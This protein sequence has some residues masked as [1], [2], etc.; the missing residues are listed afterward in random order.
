[1]IRLQRWYDAN[2]AANADIESPSVSKRTPKGEKTW[3]TVVDRDFCDLT[4]EVW[5][6]VL[7]QELSTNVAFVL[8]NFD[9]QQS[10]SDQARILGDRLH[11]KR[12]I[13]V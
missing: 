11:E 6:E 7:N 1:M 8:D 9:V 3:M 10:V 13:R 4:V 5:L 2:V 12:Q